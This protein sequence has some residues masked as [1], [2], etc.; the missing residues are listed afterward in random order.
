MIDDL[1]K[2]SERLSLFTTGTGA[3]PNYNTSSSDPAA[4]LRSQTAVTTAP[5][6]TVRPVTLGSPGLPSQPQA[7]E[8]QLNLGSPVDS[9]VV[10][11]RPPA[12]G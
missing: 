11:N 4:G 10:L 8:G 5:V 3:A 1:Q 6:I 2:I 7:D 9:L 12:L